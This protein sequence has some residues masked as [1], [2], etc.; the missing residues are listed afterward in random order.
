MAVSDQEVA[1]WL[2]ANPNATDAQIAQAAAAAG[3]SAQQL[4]SVTGL[5]VNEVNNRIAAATTPVTSAELPTLK[6]Y[7]GEEYQGKQVLDLAKQLAGITDFKSLSGGV[8]GESKPSVG[9]DYTE[10]QK[11]LGRDPTTVDQVLLD[12]AANLI[13]QGITDVSQLKPNTRQPDETL[14]ETMVDPNIYAGQT[15]SG[16]G[17][18]SR[19]QMKNGFCFKACVCCCYRRTFESREVN[20]LA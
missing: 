16:P 7:T 13:K 8:F 20:E 9:F 11:L 3:V 4:A 17:V 12:A 1:A 18:T 19:P 6:Y 14:G 5:P 15:Y 2:A 10:A